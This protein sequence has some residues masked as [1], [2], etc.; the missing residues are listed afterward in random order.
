M[1]NKILLIKR[2]V[3]EIITDEMKNIFPIENSENIFIGIFLPKKT[4]NKI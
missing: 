4:I 1:N 2:F 3:F